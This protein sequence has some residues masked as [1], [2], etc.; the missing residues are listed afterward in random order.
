MGILTGQEL[1]E[2]DSGFF[3]IATELVT[4]KT[5]DDSGACFFQFVAIFERYLYYIL[6]ALD[7]MLKKTHSSECK[8]NK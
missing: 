2:S 6:G 1:Q 5:D 4:I 7:I 3:Q 8:S